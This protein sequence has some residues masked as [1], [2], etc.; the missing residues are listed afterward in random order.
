MPR[1]IY[2]RSPELIAEMIERL[3]HYPKPGAPKGT[4]HSELSKLHMSLAHKGM[5]PSTAGWN[6]GLTYTRSDHKYINEQA[7]FRK[8]RYYIVDYSRRDRSVYVPRAVLV[9]EQYLGRKLIK[10]EI[11]HHLNRIKTDDRIENLKLFSSVGE[12]MKE[13]HN[14]LGH[15][16]P[17]P[18]VYKPRVLKVQKRFLGI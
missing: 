18:F 5:K 7:F 9:M 2:K 3:K 4:K 17:K 14:I 6:K 13:H 16:T 8:G 12:H 10:G 15:K 1:G 11:V